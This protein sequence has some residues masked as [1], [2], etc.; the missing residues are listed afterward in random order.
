MALSD[1]AMPASIDPQVLRFPLLSNVAWPDGHDRQVASRVSYAAAFSRPR[2]AT[3]VRHSD[4][5]A[6]AADF[7]RF[8]PA[9]SSDG[10]SAWIEG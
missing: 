5:A 10:R 8:V 3:R 1:D 2:P 7:A 9:V 6:V 4:D